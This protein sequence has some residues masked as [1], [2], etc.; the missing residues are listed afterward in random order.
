M[1]VWYPF[2]MSSTKYPPVV[3]VDENDNEIGSATLADV[4]QKGSYHR[5]VS[6]F[7]EDEQGNM[8]LQFRGP[9]VKAFPNCWDQ[10]IGGHVDLGH[11]Y[12]QTATL[13]AEEELGLHDLSL[14]ELGTCRSNTQEGDR[15][16]NQF[17]RVYS[18]QIPHDTL[19][20]PQA[21]EISSLRWFTLSELRAEI[22]KSP[23]KFTTGLVLCL[24]KYFP[25]VGL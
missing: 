4:W 1:N 10:A 8:L 7:V 24:K 6:V 14:K 9:N 22:A 25:S 5:I 23:D 12:E 20:K 2:L 15:I 3:V 16:V 21:D 11:T 13:E 19:L 18:I 17:E